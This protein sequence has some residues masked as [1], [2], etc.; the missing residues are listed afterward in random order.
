MKFDIFDAQIIRPDSLSLPEGT[1]FPQHDDIVYVPIPFT[2]AKT[3]KPDHIVSIDIQAETVLGIRMERTEGTVSVLS[4]RLEPDTQMGFSVIGEIRGGLDSMASG[5]RGYCKMDLDGILDVVV[6]GH[7]V[8]W[9]VV[10][11][12]GES[13]PK[14]E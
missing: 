11:V 9:R 3:M 4:G 1:L 5:S 6:G 7:V 2:L 8:C 12:D 14:R 10:R 13:K